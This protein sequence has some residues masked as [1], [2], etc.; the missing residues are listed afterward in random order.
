MSKSPIIWKISGK[1]ADQEAF[2]RL[3]ATLVRQSREEAGTRQYWWCQDAL[4]AGY[5]DIDVYEDEEAALAHLENWQQHADAFADVAS[6]ESCFVYGQVSD[7]IREQLAPLNPC[8][9]EY[10]GGFLKEKQLN[11][12]S[13]C[14]DIVWTMEGR[15]TDSDLF[16]E[17]MHQLTEHAKLEK[18]TLMHWW[19]LHDICVQGEL[20]G[21][22]SENCQRKAFHVMERYADTAAALDH[23]KIWDQFGKLF[24]DSTDI[25]AYKVYSTLREDLAKDVE[26]L[27]P[28]YFNFFDGFAR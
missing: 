8:Y 16:H 6:I 21:E 20:Q 10:Y 26:G 15:V 18:D 2:R 5:E 19:T 25:A 3:V 28:Q 24:L 12:L 13:D 22:P 9:E 1:I 7:R 4:G 17:A 14:S 23:L 27:S 11:K